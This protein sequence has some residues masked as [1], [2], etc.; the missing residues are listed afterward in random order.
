MGVMRP[1]SSAG[2]RLTCSA[3]GGSALEACRSRAAWIVSRGS[4]STAVDCIGTRPAAHAPDDFFS[5]FS[6]M[7]FGCVDASAGAE[8]RWRER[9]AVFLGGG[10][11]QKAVP[12][13]MDARTLTVLLAICAPLAARGW[14]APG[15]LVT[16]ALAARH[17]PP[18]VR[19]A[20]AQDLLASASDAGSNFTTCAVWCVACMRAPAGGV[21]C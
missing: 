20:V 21:V 6:V 9:R 19:E 2:G 18:D 17:L 3:L 13:A 5:P 16:A 11:V 8:M 14:A 4:I 12:P 7:V 15:H 1:R 10:A